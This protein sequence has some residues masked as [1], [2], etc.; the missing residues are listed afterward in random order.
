MRQIHQSPQ[1]NSKNNVFCLITPCQAVGDFCLD[2]TITGDRESDRKTSETF[3]TNSAW[4]F[5]D[6]SRPLP[7]I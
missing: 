2:P 3:K 6:R 7:A 4:T 1:T 5:S